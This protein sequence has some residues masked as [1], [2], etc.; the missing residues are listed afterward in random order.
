MEK[1]P[2]PRTGLIQIAIFCRHGLR[3]TVYPNPKKN[4]NRRY[5]RH[6]RWCA[7]VAKNTRFDLPTARRK[8]T[9]LG[10]SRVSFVSPQWASG[11]GALAREDFGLGYTHS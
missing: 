6:H 3:Q 10:P 2:D 8:D 5:Q 9:L 11:L 4:M 1:N 7:K